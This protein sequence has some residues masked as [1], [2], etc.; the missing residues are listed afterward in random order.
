LVVLVG[1]GF[2]PNRRGPLPFLG[3]ASLPVPFIA[4]CFFV[5]ARF[6][7]VTS[8]NDDE[9]EEEDDDPHGDEEL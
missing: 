2:V 9:K 5:V 4:T 7:T 8:G 6:A 3:G 1:R